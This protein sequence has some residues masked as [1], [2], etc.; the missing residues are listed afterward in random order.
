MIRRVA[1][2]PLSSG[3]AMSI[4]DH[5]RQEFFGQL[6]RLAAVFSLAN[7]R[8]V[9]FSLQE[10][11]ILAATCMSGKV[12]LFAHT[13]S[14]FNLKGIPR[15]LARLENGRQAV[16][17]AKK[18]PAD[19]VVMDIA[20]PL[21]QRAGGYAAESSHEVPSTRVLILSSYSDDEYVQQ[22]TA[23]GAAGYLLKQTPPPN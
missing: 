5:I 1:S 16:Q 7:D 13:H 4:H 20:M 23:A 21:A 14:L 12:R 19:V 15:S 2:S 17:L 10:Q 22:L 3:M 11:W 8:D 9:R 18:L 6:H